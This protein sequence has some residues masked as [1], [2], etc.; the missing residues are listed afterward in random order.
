MQVRPVVVALPDFDERVADRRALH[1]EDLARE[2][3]DGADGGGDRVVDDDQ[4]VVGVERQLVGVERPLGLI[5]RL[6]QRLGERPADG[7]RAHSQRAGS[8]EE[9][10]AGQDGGVAHGSDL[11]WVEM[12]RLLLEYEPREGAT[13][14]AGRFED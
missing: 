10:T 2:V 1:V 9:T 14:S 5:G 11:A 3:G 12:G 6:R 4:V 8:K 7:V 13:V